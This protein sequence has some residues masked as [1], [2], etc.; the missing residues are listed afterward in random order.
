MPG[1]PAC[2][3]LTIPNCCNT[4]SF[5]HRKFLYARISLHRKALHLHH[6]FY[7]ILRQKQNPSKPFVFALEAFYTTPNSFSTTSP[8][9]HTS[10]HDNL[11]ATGLSNQ[12]RFYTHQRQKPSHNTKKFLTRN[13]VTVA[14]PFTPLDFDTRSSLHFTPQAFYTRKKPSPVETFAPKPVAPETFYIISHQTASA[15]ETFYT[16]RVLHQTHFIPHAFYTAN[17]SRQKPLTP[18]TLL[19]KHLHQKLLNFAPQVCNRTTHITHIQR[20][21]GMQKTVRMH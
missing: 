16:T 20:H 19:Q 3:C 11:F 18:P 6:Q 15:P 1:Y 12:K 14:K 17:P 9:Y 5:L 10:L 7:T 8:L 13:V 4:R 21:L 2:P